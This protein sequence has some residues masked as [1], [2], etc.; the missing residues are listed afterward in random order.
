MAGAETPTSLSTMEAST[1]HL[2]A[3]FMMLV[4]K[5]GSHLGTFRSKHTQSMF[6]PSIDSKKVRYKSDGLGRDGYIL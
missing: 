4:S 3:I 2:K 6:T 1:E 5:K